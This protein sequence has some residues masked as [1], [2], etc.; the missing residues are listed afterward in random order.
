MDYTCF[1]KNIHWPFC[2]TC[3]VRCF[4]F[5]GEGEVLEMEVEGEKMEGW[6]C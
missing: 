4:G 6:G 2:G 3:G 5:R 1:D